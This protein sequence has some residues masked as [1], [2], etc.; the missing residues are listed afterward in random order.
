MN[1]TF[2]KRAEICSNCEL[3]KYSKYID[4]IDDELKDVKGFVC[5]D[6]GCP[7]IAKIRS[8]DICKKWKHIN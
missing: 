7:L 6:C 4:F 8:T 2:K 5:G 3:R 1:E